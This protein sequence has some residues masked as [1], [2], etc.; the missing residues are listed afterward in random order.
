MS[1]LLEVMDPRDRLDFAIEFSKVFDVGETLSD[2]TWSLSTEATAA[3]VEIY[4]QGYDGTKASVWLEVASA[5]RS[6]AAWT[7]DGTKVMAGCIATSSSGR[8]RERAITVT[9]KQRNVVDG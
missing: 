2:A 4:A 7:G 9:I 3:G 6:A 5:Q 8:I 1:E